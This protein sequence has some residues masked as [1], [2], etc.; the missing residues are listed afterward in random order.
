MTTDAALIEK[1]DELKRRLEAGEYKTLV[2]VFLA[3]INRVI[4][5]IL[6]RNKPLPPWLITVILGLVV[7]LI[8]FGGRYV[9]GGLTGIR[10]IA[11]PYGVGYGSGVLLDFSLAV[12]TI[13]TVISI[14]HSIDR[15]IILWRDEMLD[16]TVSVSSLQEFEDWLGT[17]CN[18]RLHFLVTIFG[19]L[20]IALLVTALISV[21]LG[22]FVGYG[23]TFGYIIINMFTAAFFYEGFIVILLPVMLR[24]YELK[25]FAADP[26]TSELISHL[27]SELS[28]FVYFVAVYSTIFSLVIGALRTSQTTDIVVAVVLFL[29]LP[30]ITMFALNQTTLSSIIRRAK[31]KTL[32]EIQARVEKLQAA[33][34]LD[35]KET[36]DAI[37]RLLDYH[38]RVNRTRASALDFRAILGFINSLILPLLAFLLDKVLLP[39]TGKP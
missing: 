3:W 32:N 22:A 12:L 20:L 4:Q 5:R 23:T 35:A 24:K 8:L 34:N 6:R 26:A 11:K 7:N 16:A 17:A 10:N 25:L 21:R 33:E 38:E 1:R 27:S 2:D 13:I 36:M 15:F 18:L 29:W 28:F 31:W 14:N 39:F 30:I 19:G 37:N 9:D